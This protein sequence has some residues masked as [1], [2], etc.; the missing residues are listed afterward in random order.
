MKTDGPVIAYYDALCPLC[1]R[2]MRHYAKFG[3]EK[4]ILSDCNAPDLAEDIDR[5]AALAAMHVRLPDNTI[6]TGVD[7]F[8]AIWERLPRWH[9]LATVLRPWIIRKPLDV[10]Y[11]FLAPYRPRQTCRDG[12]CSTD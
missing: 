11:R 12:V 7:A 4:I 1:R 6:A 3:P 2:E 10:I 5:D 8:I 9:M